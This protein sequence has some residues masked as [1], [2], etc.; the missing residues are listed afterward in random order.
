MTTEREKFTATFML[1]PI[2]ELNLDKDLRWHGWR[3][4][5]EQKDAE[6]AQYRKQAHEDYR[7]QNDAI[8][9][10]QERIAEL[11]AELAALREDRAA[12]KREALEEV[13]K[14]LVRLDDRGV[15][16]HELDRMIQEIKP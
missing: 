9:K 14:Q 3:A 11:E 16:I 4:C 1:G 5:A 10:Q 12:A 15:G 7:I 6:H 2:E 13:K 8:V